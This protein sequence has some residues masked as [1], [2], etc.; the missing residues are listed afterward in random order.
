VSNW[1]PARCEAF[2]VYAREHGRARP[3]CVSNQLS[4]P[5]MLEPVWPGCVRADEAWHERTGTPLLAWSAQGRGYLSGR[6]S[7]DPEVRRC[8]DS[9]GNEARRDAA[10][11]IAAA[12]GVAPVAIAL[13]WLL[14]RPFPVWAVIG[15]RS[16]D[17]LAACLAAFDVPAGAVEGL[18]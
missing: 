12:L 17:E 3:S 8:W 5:E 1:A 7:G 9:P 4:L 15:P 10:E 6:G 16:R 13:A 18:S 11:R 2:D 14:V